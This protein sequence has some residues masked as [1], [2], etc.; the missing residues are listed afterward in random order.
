MS[1]DGRRE[2]PKWVVSVERDQRNRRAGWMAQLYAGDELVLAAPSAHGASDRDA[3]SF[4]Q[5]IR[6][7]LPEAEVRRA[8]TLAER[9]EADTQKVENKARREKEKRSRLMAIRDQVRRLAEEDSWTF[10][11]WNEFTDGV[12]DLRYGTDE[13]DDDDEW[14]YESE[15]DE[16]A[17]PRNLEW[18]VQE[19]GARPTGVLFYGS[20]PVLSTTGQLRVEAVRDLIEWSRTT[21]VTHA[22]IERR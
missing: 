15:Q 1:P 4:L 20:S 11:D 3:E 6:S 22:P 17:I 21:D 8:P 19:E 12:D 2:K 13:D 10:D 5:I 14:P 16:P 7:G 9:I 18:E